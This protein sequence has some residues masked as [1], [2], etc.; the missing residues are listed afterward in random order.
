LDVLVF[1]VLFFKKDLQVFFL[2]VRVAIWLQVVIS[3]CHHFVELKLCPH[4]IMLV[5]CLHFH[6]CVAP[7]INCAWVVP[8]FHR[9]KINV[10]LIFLF[11]LFA[12]GSCD[13]ANPCKVLH[14]VVL[15]DMFEF[16][17]K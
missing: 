8:T 2:L 16:M 1:F 15:I 14:K 6:V 12:L 9:F 5:L 17:M 11:M 7:T 4:F 13:F 10:F 3:L